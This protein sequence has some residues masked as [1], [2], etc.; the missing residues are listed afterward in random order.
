MAK[1]HWFFRA[2][3]S[4]LILCAVSCSEKKVPIDTIRAFFAAV[5]S[6]D[7]ETAQS[8]VCEKQRGQVLESL[9]PFE[10]V[11]SLSEAFDM[12]FED[13]EFSERSND[14]AL[15]VVQVTGKV[16]LA[17]LGTED[18]QDVFEEHILEN[19]D[20]RWVICDP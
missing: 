7:L 5:E 13:L 10:N 17:F 18:V 19:V 15:A 3:L 11:T 9:A 6:Y 14:G 8:L 12:T 16:R 4:I 20:G 1:S 2:L